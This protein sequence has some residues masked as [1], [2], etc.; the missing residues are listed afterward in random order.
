MFICF[1][2]SE[3]LSTVSWLQGRDVK[4]DGQSCLM[5]RKQSRK[6]QEKK[7]YLRSNSHDIVRY[8]QKCAL[9]ILRVD[10]KPIKLTVSTKFMFRNKIVYIF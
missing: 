3:I 7:E 10:L 8:T 1:T 2:V 6:V 9:L 5:D 4:L